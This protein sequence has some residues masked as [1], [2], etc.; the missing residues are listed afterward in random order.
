M[1][2][3]DHHLGAAAI[4]PPLGLGMAFLIPS[5]AVCL[6]CLFGALVLGAVATGHRRRLM[7]PTTFSLL[8][9]T[10]IIVALAVWSVI[11]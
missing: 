8:T 6:V 5:L 9:L 1:D 11:T 4:V 3:L 10:L 2:A 7:V